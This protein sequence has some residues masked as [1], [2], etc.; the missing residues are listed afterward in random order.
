MTPTVWDGYQ[1]IYGTGYRFQ[2]STSKSQRVDT[3]GGIRKLRDN[4]FRPA[5][6]PLN[7][8]IE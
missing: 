5:Y 7:F 1:G 4:F 8:F 6:S 2:V 3:P